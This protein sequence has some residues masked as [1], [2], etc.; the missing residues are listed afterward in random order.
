MRI[1]RVVWWNLVAAMVVL[2][3]AGPAGAFYWYGWP[4]SQIPPPRTIVT[5]PHKNHPGT[6]PEV[7]PVGPPIETPP[8]GPPSP[9][10]EPAT[11]LAALAGLGALAAARAWRRGRESSAKRR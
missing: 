1:R 6:P 10:P 5:P 8:G 9:T 11:A 7:P 4:G 3:S 2:V